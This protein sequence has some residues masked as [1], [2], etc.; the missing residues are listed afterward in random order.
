MDNKELAAY[1]EAHPKETELYVVKN[2]VS[3]E[4][5]FMGSQKAHADNYAKGNKDNITTYKKSDV[6]EKVAKKA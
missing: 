1:F 6:V 4:Q 2:S 5:V 3:G